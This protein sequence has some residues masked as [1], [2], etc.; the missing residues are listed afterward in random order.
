[1][2]IAR[3]AI[4][5]P[6]DTLFDYLP[7]PATAADV[8]RRVLVP[9]GRTDTVGVLYGFAAAEEPFDRK[10][11]PVARVLQ[12][13]QPLDDRILRLLDF[14]ARY[15]HYPLGATV[16]G[17]LP[18]RLR[19]IG[20]LPSKLAKV[21]ALSESGRKR[22]LAQAPARIS[23]QWRILRLLAVED[24]TGSAPL[25]AL[26]PGAPAALRRL[27]TARYVEEKAFV[28][29][30]VEPAP[31]IAYPILRPTLT[32]EQ[33]RAVEA[34]CAGNEQYRP[35]L[36]H[37][38]TGSGKTEVYLRALE[39]ALSQGK[40]VLYLVPEINLT[41]QLEAFLRS[42][43]A[44]ARLIPLHSGLG[45]GD[46]ARN[47]IAA[48]RGEADIILGTR[49]AVFTPIPR[50]GLIVVDEEHD[51]SFK[52]Q[53][54]LRYSARDVAVMRARQAGIPIVL[55]SATPALES[56][57]QALAGRYGLL[58]LNSRPSG[59]SPAISLVDTGRECLQEGLS[60]TVRKALVDCL[61]RGEQGLVFI[62][63]RGYAPALYCRA[64]RWI[65]GCPRCSSRLV[66]HLRDRKLAC[67]GCGHEERLPVACVQCGNQ[68]LA[69]VGQGTQRVEQFLATEFPRARLLRVDRDSTRG[70]IV[71]QGMREEIAAERVD[72]LVGTQML[73]KGHD[74]PKLTLVAVL[75]ADSALF[76]TD[77]RA[78][79]R[80][81]AQLV[82]VAGRAGR[83]SRPGEVLI[84][85]EFPDHPLFQ[86]VLA[87]DYDRFAQAQL[88]ERRRA[89]FPP[90]S[91]QALLRA[92]ATRSGAELDF[93]ERAAA[94]GRALALD[95]SVRV[96]DPVPALRAR[97]AGLD[98]AQLLVQAEARTKLQ[99][100][101]HKWCP[102]LGALAGRKVRWTVDVDPLD[103]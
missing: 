39:Q 100:F 78:A 8:G 85:T 86:A 9:F 81:F 7:G 77:F 59:R 48:Q 17:A 89:R 92:E 88:A 2:E 65:A 12:D 53:E 1:M 97:V 16:M 91:Y 98:R 55:G 18:P 87:Q 95:S 60:A 45:E 101:L 67:H 14:C 10:L 50:L 44:E 47:W 54:G 83:G 33:A 64:C 31:I 25:R 28:A 96:Y 73:A 35:W 52:Q 43:A 56:Y 15:Y 94:E 4:D 29:P 36:L 42:R 102:S 68:D 37:G 6:V 70:K 11:K 75:N 22:A 41:P 24:E 46:R 80:L 5:V 93:L 19:R 74:F 3:V 34:I 63:R 72:I 40:Q 21:Y 62:N 58:R 49:L 84:Q 51:A 82:Q 38:I 66:V 23:L 71:W 20:A 27:V 13:V 32:Q 103:L 90:F 79:E 30:A 76:S 61:D 26:G 57:A 99:A 69:P